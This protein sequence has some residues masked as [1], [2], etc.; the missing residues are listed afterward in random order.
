MVE[1][2]EELMH[3]LHHLQNLYIVLSSDPPSFAVVEGA[4]MIP[5]VLGQAI[6]GAMAE[7]GVRVVMWASGLGRV[8][9]CMLCGAHTH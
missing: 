9:T 3:S 4:G 5:H 1:V 7:V 6:R 2:A 8:P